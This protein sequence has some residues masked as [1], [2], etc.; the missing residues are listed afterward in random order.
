MSNWLKK[1]FG[2]IIGV[3]LLFLGIEK[4]KNKKQAEKIAES[5]TQIKNMDYRIK[6]QKTTDKAK[7][8]ILEAQADNRKKKV[9]NEKQIKEAEVIENVEEKSAKQEE[10]VNSITDL[11]NARNSTL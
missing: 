4:R 2:G 10:V 11:F 7:D 8:E 5:E 1:L 9:E 3:L 6:V